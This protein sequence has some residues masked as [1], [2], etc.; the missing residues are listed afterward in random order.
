MHVVT[1]NHGDEES[2]V[3]TTII[4]SS[5]CDANVSS[6][7]ED[8]RTNAALESPS[9]RLPRTVLRSASHV[10]AATAASTLHH[11]LHDDESDRDDEQTV[12]MLMQ[13]NQRR[14]ISQ[15]H[16]LDER[17]S[18]SSSIGAQQQTQHVTGETSTVRSS[19]V[20]L[21]AQRQ[22]RYSS[23]SSVLHRQ[24]LGPTDSASLSFNS[25]PTAA[26]RQ[27]QSGASSK[28]KGQSTRGPNIVHTLWAREVR[29][30]NHTKRR[31][32]T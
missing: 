18:S 25:S 20:T 31:F 16:E 22:R 10:A 4:E 15:D 19:L 7:T 8:Q 17:S 2:L 21:Q 30:R 28:A 12:A 29:A 13:E 14:R 23:L 27:S 11:D 5:D 9:S 24:R 6:S 32:V 1:L 3:Q 26:V